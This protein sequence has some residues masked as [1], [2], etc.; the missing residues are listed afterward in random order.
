V[1]SVSTGRRRA[2]SSLHACRDGERQGD[3]Y[4]SDVKWAVAQANL[5]GADK[6]PESTSYNGKEEH[7]PMA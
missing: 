4:R 1:I 5:H 2:C 6:R 7:R 3:Q